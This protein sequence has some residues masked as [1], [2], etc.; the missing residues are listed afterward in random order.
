[1]RPLTDHT[2]KPLLK[3]AG[4]PLIEHHIRRL[5]EAD[6]SEIVIN[7]CH[8]AEQIVEY[9]G[10][11][12][13]WG[14]PIVFSR[15]SEALETA[16]GIVQALPLLGEQPFLVVNG[17]VWT[18]YPFAQL[19]QRGWDH[20]EKGAHLVLVDNP[21]QHSRGDFV[22]RPNGELQFFAEDLCGL[23]YAGV[24]VYSVGFFAGLTLGKIPLLPLLEQAISE[25]RL[26]GEHY[27]GVWADVGTPERLEALND[28][29]T[30]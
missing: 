13:R 26:S 28:V 5:V 22:L 6:V 23:T 27:Q 25:N 2:P 21:P 12:R 8:L 4:V 10:D 1:M 17:D 7:V 16:G 18:D 29:V 15:E 3:V 14:V 9:C 30:T 19:L 20:L 24:A 11:G